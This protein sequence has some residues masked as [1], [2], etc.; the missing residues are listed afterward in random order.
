MQRKHR[1]MQ[2]EN[3]L[4]NAKTRR[5]TRLSYAV[6]QLENVWT[7]ENLLSNAKTCFPLSKTSYPMPKT[8][9]IIYTPYT[10]I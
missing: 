5:L 10:N 3:V 2:R 4:S 6:D 1:V 7:N 9:N 8:W